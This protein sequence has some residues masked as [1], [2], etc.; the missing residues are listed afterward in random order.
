MARLNS[1]YLPPDQWAEPYVLDGT[2]AGHLLR[3]LRARPGERVRLFDGRGREGIFVL[4][5]ADTRQAW[6]DPEE[7]A[8]RERPAGRPWLALGWSKA[9][10]RDLL[11]EKAVEL[12]AGGLVF[13]RAE[14]SQGDLPEA[15]KPG[16]AATMIQAAKQC[17]ETWLPDVA[18]VPD[19]WAAWPC[20][21]PRA[22][23]PPERPR[24]SS[25]PVSP[26]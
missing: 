19:G 22:G 6:L 11:L 7:I 12:R 20:S 23:W 13:W 18:L 25:R 8:T 17:G 14:R 4:A 16:W 5:R 21:A 15:P 2:E 3:V 10:R 26:P 1:F 24:G 9:G